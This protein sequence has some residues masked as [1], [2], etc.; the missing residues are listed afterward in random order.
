VDIAS[1]YYEFFIESMNGHA[2]DAA[3]TAAK[4]PAVR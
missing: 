1:V 4:P 3:P 2:K